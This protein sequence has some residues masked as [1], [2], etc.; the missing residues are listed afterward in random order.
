MR[1]EDMLPACEKLDRVGFWSLEV[2][3]GATFD[4]CLRFLKEDPWER[5]RR[6]R[7]ALPRTRLQ[8][9]LRAQALVGYRHYADDTVRK[10]IDLSAQNG[11]DV[12][13]IFDAMNDPANLKTAV[14][15]TVSI[16]KHAQG[17][18]CYTTSPAHTSGHFVDLAETL[19]EW[20]CQSI[21]IKDMA[22]LL[23]PLAVEELVLRLRERLPGIPLHL[24]THAT[25]GLAELNH[26]K[27]IEAGVA[28]IDTALSALAGGASHPPTESMVAALAGTPFDTGLDL[29]ELQEISAYFREVRKKYHRFES[30]LTG[31]DTRVLV[32]QLPGGMLSNLVNQ[33]REQ[34]ALDRME[35]V[36]EEVPRVRADF[37]YPPLVTPTSQIV[38]TQAVLNVLTGSRYKVFTTESRNYLSGMYGRSIM[39]PNPEVVARALKPGEQPITCRPADLLAPELEKAAKELGALARS[40]ED[41][42]S[43]VL[44]PQV[45]MDFFKAR[46]AQTLTPEPLEA[47]AVG[48]PL[49]PHHLAPTEFT[50]T[51]HGETYHVHVSGVGHKEQNRRPFFL[52]VDGVLEEVL[53]EAVTEILPSA[54]GR[55]L[56]RQAGL[57]SVRLKPSGPGDVSAPM[58][59]RVTAVLVHVGEAVAK[60][61]AV[62]V[63][64][65]M[66][67]ETQVHAPI[68]GKV[69][70]LLVAVGDAVNPD[71]TLLRIEGE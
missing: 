7:A 1:T 37:G 28:V 61:Q 58:P 22:G 56:T 5:L 68:A 51:L 57:D 4:A 50:V 20:G 32:H 13:R 27:A 55:V 25:A 15:H 12:F 66:K 65:A 62:L 29:V 63:V 9:L 19:A 53:V 69:T 60:G 2:W 52:R 16:G 41:V 45:A 23:T 11:M 46:E 30:D 18:L 47:A 24:H 8:M 35:E 54:E 17:A 38:G 59:G 48:A 26:L 10:F 71:E 21:A 6:F 42:V 34:E 44:F 43:Y 67:M 3:G 36:L 40:E 70:A 14:T 49:P 31:V 33:L 64:E 39:P